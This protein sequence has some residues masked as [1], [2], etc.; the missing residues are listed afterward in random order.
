MPVPRPGQDVRH[1]ML[2]LSTGCHDRWRISATLNQRD[3]QL[4]ILNLSRRV[5]IRPLHPGRMLAFLHEGGLIDN[6]NRFRVA[7]MVGDI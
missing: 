7:Q 3:A 4:T 1:Y 2:H 5:T 6:H